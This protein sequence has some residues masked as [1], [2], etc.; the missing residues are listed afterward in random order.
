MLSAYPPVALGGTP[1]ALI[2]EI[3][4]H[5]VIS[6]SVAAENPLKRVKAIKYM[7][8]LIQ[9]TTPKVGLGAAIVA[10]TN[11]AF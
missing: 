10:D 5:E 9:G 3:D 4:E 2:A 7:S 6:E 11:T 8:E 1:W